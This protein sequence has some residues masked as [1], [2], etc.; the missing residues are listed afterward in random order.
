MGA[1]EIE[2]AMGRATALQ[3]RG[4]TD[5][6]AALYRQIL[7]QHRTLAPAHYNLALLL[8]DQGKTLAA[9]KSFKAAVTADSAYS[10]G[11]RG[12]A[13]FLAERGKYREAIRAG[14]QAAALEEYAP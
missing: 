12:Y 5:A 2:Q 10:L 3:R 8:K 1:G 13:R 7:K 4:E 14:L 9:E 6:A 11:W